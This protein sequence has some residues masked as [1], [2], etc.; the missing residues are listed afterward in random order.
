M[1]VYLLFFI[2]IM[3][4]CSKTTT[5]NLGGT[6]S[7]V[8]EGLYKYI[9]AGN[10]YLN[11][12]IPASI[13]KYQYDSTFIVAKQKTNRTI[14]KYFLGSELYRRYFLYNYFLEDSNRVKKEMPHFVIEGIKKDRDIYN[15]LKA[16]EVSFE[17]S[18]S[19]VL[20][21]NKV[22]DSILA[23]DIYYKKLFSRTRNYWIVDK[24]KNILYGPFDFK[25]LE[26]E[27]KN[28]G[29]QVALEE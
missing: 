14:Y 6:Y 2:L 24:G 7:L 22:A 25:G 8:D 28:L 9:S 13:E 17:E 23:N 11:S 29:V 19:D 5:K 4:G 15:L 20:T 1:K 21:A 3:A 12:S 16:K 10:V 26:S 27:R 18:V